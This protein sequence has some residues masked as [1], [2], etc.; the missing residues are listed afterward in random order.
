MCDRFRGGIAFLKGGFSS[1]NGQQALVAMFKPFRQVVLA[2]YNPQYRVERCFTAIAMPQ[3]GLAGDF[4]AGYKE[5]QF[6]T[7][8]P[9]RALG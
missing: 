3:A 4:I 8:K 9:A 6:R 7:A 1:D 5:P 2:I